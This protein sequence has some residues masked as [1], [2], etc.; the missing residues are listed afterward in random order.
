[1]LIVGEPYNIQNFVLTLL[2]G[3]NK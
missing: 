3:K 2:Y 1:M